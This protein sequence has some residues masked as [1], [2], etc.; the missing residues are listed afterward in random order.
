MRSHY[1]ET[2]L[3]AKTLHA[4]FQLYFAYDLNRIDLCVVVLL[5]GG[6]LHLQEWKVGLLRLQFPVFSIYGG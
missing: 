1:A 4:A 6:R 2:I 5:R 3:G